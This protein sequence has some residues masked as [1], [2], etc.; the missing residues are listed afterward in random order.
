MKRGHLQVRTLDFLICT[1]ESQKNKRR[2]VSFRPPLPT[3]TQIKD[4]PGE[5][6]LPN[7]TG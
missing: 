7:R 4:V 3:I 2:T 5:K 1:D 6:T